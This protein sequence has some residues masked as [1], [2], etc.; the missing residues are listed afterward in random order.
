MIAALAAVQDGGQ[1]DQNYYT[2][3]DIDNIDF[4]INRIQAIAPL[5]GQDFWVFFLK[6]C[7]SLKIRT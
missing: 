4:D 7:I 1:E 2:P 3:L 5:T 6:G